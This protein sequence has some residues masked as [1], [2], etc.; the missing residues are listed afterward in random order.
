MDKRLKEISSRLSEYSLG[1]F[2][3]RLALSPHLDELDAVI[4]GINMLGEELK[5]ITISKNYFTNIFNAVSDM[6]FI[7]NNKGRVED[8]NRSAEQQL[9]YE[10]GGLAGKNFNELHPSKASFFNQVKKQLQRSHPLKI[11]ESYLNTFEGGRVYVMINVVYFKN[12]RK[13]KL[14]L[15]TASDISYQLKAENLIIRAIID[16]Q[17]KERQRLAKDLHDS[18]TQQLS[19]IKL[20]ISSMADA[21]KNK[22]QK[23]ILVKS[24]DALTEVI[25]DMRNI[26]FNLMPKTL[27]TFGLIKAVR[28]FCNHFLYHRKIQFTVHEKTRLPVFSSALAIDLY[29][30]IQEFITNAIRHGHASKICISFSYSKKILNVLLLDNGTGFDGEQAAKGMGLQNVQSRVKSHN[31]SLHIK[32]AVD[33]GTQ[34][35]IAIPLNN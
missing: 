27:E 3:K 7:L 22:M 9:Q 31:G 13:K 18:L 6:V 28:E 32:S 33:T 11:N 23:E 34:Y 30:V 4:N 1:R 8:V 19:A 29:R 12:E 26:C 20:Y 21:V 2:E 17:E 35:K 10:H 16:T 15:L 25:T 14:L 24:N 5:S